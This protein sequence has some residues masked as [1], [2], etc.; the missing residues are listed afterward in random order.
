MVHHLGDVQRTIL[1]QLDTKGLTYIDLVSRS[2]VT[3]I[4]RFSG[5][6]NCFNRWCIS[7]ICSRTNGAKNEQP[8]TNG[9]LHHAITPYARHDTCGIS[10]H[11][12]LAGSD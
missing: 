12:D 4:R 9:L 11:V 6:G 1:S 7:C 10:L 2:G 5:A 8:N 3:V